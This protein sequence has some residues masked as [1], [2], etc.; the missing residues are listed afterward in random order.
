MPVRISLDSKSADNMFKRDISM[1]EH[2]TL[3]FEFCEVYNIS[4]SVSNC[5]YQ[6]SKIAIFFDCK[7]NYFV[8][9]RENIG[10]NIEEP[11][12]KR[13]K[14]SETSFIGRNDDVLVRTVYMTPA[15][16]HVSNE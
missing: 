12:S 5:K 10:M 3:T 11:T 4:T 6:S 14:L 7:K 8:L 9:D 16:P 15:K 2:R 1:L 13:P